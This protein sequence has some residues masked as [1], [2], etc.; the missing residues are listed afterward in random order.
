MSR[1][2]EP[3]NE[4]LEIEKLLEPFS[5][6]LGDKPTLKVLLIEFGRKSKEHFEN[7]Q[8]SVKVAWLGGKVGTYFYK[9]GNKESR[10]LITAGLLHDLGKKY[11]S[12]N[13]LDNRNDHLTVDQQKEIAQH[14]FYS[15]EMITGEGVPK[16]ERPNDRVMYLVGSHH[17]VWKNEQ[18][19]NTQP[20]AK[21]YPRKTRAII[22]AGENKRA[23]IDPL[24]G[25]LARV[26]AILDRMQATT[27]GKRKTEDVKKELFIHIDSDSLLNSTTKT[28]LKQ[29]V[30]FAERLIS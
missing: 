4:D 14:P 3:R 26:L 10:D 8:H 11:I 22:S 23:N 24:M 5:D 6:V 29:I 18:N 19:G 21:S 25:E 1:E 12:V 20:L 28:K 27:R 16:N 9:R 7:L 2:A 30:D 17:E 13:T 15:I